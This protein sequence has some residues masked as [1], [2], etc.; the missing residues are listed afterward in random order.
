M[1]EARAF[2]RPDINVHFYGVV[3]PFANLEPYLGARGIVSQSECGLKVTAGLDAA[4]GFRIGILDDDT[5][6]YSMPIPG[7]VKDLFEATCEAPGVARVEILPPTTELPVG[8]TAQLTAVLY[9][10][11]DNILTDREVA[12]TTSNPGI[13]TVST[14]VGQVVTVT[15]VS[16]GVAELT[17]TSEGFSDMALVAVS[18][19]TG[20][21]VVSGTWRGITC[22][23]RDFGCEYATSGDWVWTLTESNGTISGTINWVGGWWF[24]TKLDLQPSGRPCTVTG[25][26]REL[27]GPDL[28]WYDEVRVDCGPVAVPGTTIVYSGV[29]NGGFSLSTDPYDGGLV[30]E[31]G[32]YQAPDNNIGTHG[33]APIYLRPFQ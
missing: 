23:K 24:Y 25:S 13:V 27:S 17:A 1:I 16:L 28:K 8:G 26:V 22:L 12:W 9:D 21:L 6:D 33:S 3:G 11:E 14:A 19:P 18:E 15:G 20:E 4:V 29:F 32:L 7:P 31:G 30:I 5:E 10:A 2:V